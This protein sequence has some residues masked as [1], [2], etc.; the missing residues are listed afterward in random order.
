MSIQHCALN[1]TLR[2]AVRSGVPG[3]AAIAV[4]RDGVIDEG[5]A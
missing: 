4:S 5:A 1:E 3:V 2:T